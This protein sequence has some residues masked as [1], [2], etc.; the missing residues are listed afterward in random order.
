LPICQVGRRKLHLPA[1]QRDVCRRNLGRDVV[2]GVRPDDVCI[3]WHEA[4]HVN[5]WPMHV[6]L[7]EPWGPGSLIL[8]EADGI[9][10][11]AFVNGAAKNAAGDRLPVE[12]RLERGLLFDAVTGLNLKFEHA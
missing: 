7:T 3:Q 9:R 5:D 2:L 4:G 11:T 8:C 12:V 1:S 10:L 6:L